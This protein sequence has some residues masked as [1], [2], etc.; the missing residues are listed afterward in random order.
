[1]HRTLSTHQ[2]SLKS[3][4]LFVDG[5][6]YVWTDIETGS[7]S[8]TCACQSNNTHIHTE[9]SLNDDIMHRHPRTKD[10]KLH[11]ICNYNKNIKQDVRITCDKL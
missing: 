8:G 10:T 5:C 2:I 1:M 7:I 3:E 11:A 9:S 6:T 4:K